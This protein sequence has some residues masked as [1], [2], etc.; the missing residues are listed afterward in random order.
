MRH[1]TFINRVSFRHQDRG[2]REGWNSK[3]FKVFRARRVR[4][5]ARLT[6]TW[7]NAEQLDGARPW[8]MRLRRVGGTERILAQGSLRLWAVAWSHLQIEDRACVWGVL[9][10]TWATTFMPA[11]LDLI[12]R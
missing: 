2:G 10:T 1:R 5:I 7:I 4:D 6:A 9:T 8:D 11:M 3:A 12:C